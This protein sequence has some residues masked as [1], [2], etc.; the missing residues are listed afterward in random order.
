MHDALADL[1]WCRSPDEFMALKPAPYIAG[2]E[3]ELEAVAEFARFVAS[4]NTSW[5]IMLF[6]W[7]GTAKT[8]FP[9]ALARKLNEGGQP[10]GLAQIRCQGLTAKLNV[11]DVRQ[12]LEQ[13][14]DFLARSADPKII[15]FD[16]LDAFAPKR[17]DNP[18]L[19]RLSTW[20][21]DFFDSDSPR[22][23]QTLLMGITNNPS[24]VDPA[25]RDRVPCSLYFDLP[26]RDVVEAMLGHIGMPQAGRVADE[27][28]QQ[29]AGRREH[30]TGRSVFSTANLAIAR[31]KKTLETMNPGVIAQFML[32]HGNA[33]SEQELAG[34]RLGHRGL[35][36]R[37]KDFVD[38]WSPTTTSAA[39]S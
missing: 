21:M 25:V 27:L 9:R 39:V 32:A 4:S 28:F 22:L 13:L 37:S 34:F 33:V 8:I 16:E 35:I 6:G 10:F 11:D 3:V 1:V 5:A 14:D 2:H 17:R 18:S 19:L 36:S 30:A 31:F 23:E 20:V 29:L 38:A 7:P 26:D 15:V 12:R 24:E